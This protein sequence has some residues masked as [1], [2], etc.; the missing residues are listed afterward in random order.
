MYG[1]NGNGIKEEQRISDKG[2]HKVSINNT[3]YYIAHTDTW[4]QTTFSVL[5]I[6]L[7]FCSTVSPLSLQVISN[8]LVFMR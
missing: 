6:M 4:I 8:K 5:S 1:K 2:P 7:L 3:R